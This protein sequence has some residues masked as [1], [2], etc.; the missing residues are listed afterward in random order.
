[1]RP[2]AA[3]G[4]GFLVH[5]VCK[6][7]HTSGHMLRQPVGNLIGRFQK[8][9]V[10]ALLN[11]KLIS[12]LDAEG[13]GPGLQVGDS[14]LGKGYRIAQTAVLQNQKGRHQLGDAGRTMLGICIFFIQNPVMGGIV[15]NCCV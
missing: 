3:Q 10:E 2:R 7:A 14:A 8:E 1:M 11:G 4:C 12:R 13:H 5:Q 6:R 15:E 9:A